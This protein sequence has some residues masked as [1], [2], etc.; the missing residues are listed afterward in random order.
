MSGMTCARTMVFWLMA[1]I[2]L[3][4]V[5]VMPSGAEAHA[6]HARHGAADAVRAL[7]V[8]DTTLRAPALALSARSSVE[9][10]LTRA[11]DGSCCHIPGTPCC[12][13][14]A[15]APNAQAA[16]PRRPAGA[17]ALARAFPARTDVV[18]EA[19]PKPPR[20]AA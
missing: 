13:G 12:T 17:R 14:A 9:T 3:I 5:G 2:V 18:P 4:A 16:L 8:V 20:S 10:R 7:V 15:L 19:L 11:C 6:G 1:V